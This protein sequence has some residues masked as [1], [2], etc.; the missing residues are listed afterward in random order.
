MARYVVFLRGRMTVYRAC[1]E[2][3]AAAD[4]AAMMPHLNVQE[5]SRRCWMRAR[6]T[7]DGVAGFIYYG[8][9][10]TCP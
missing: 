2:R 9:E 10:P 7:S 6:L 3:M 5:I 1:T 4:P 8:P